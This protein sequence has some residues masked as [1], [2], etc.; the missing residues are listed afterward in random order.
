MPLMH[1]ALVTRRTA[2]RPS[3]W[4]LR[5]WACSSRAH[6][7]AVYWTAAA[8]VD[9]N[10]FSQQVTLS[11]GVVEACIPEGE[12]NAIEEGCVTYHDVVL[13]DA[14]GRLVDFSVGSERI[15]ERVVAGDGRLAS[16]EGVTIELV[17]AHQD[18]SGDLLTLF[19]STTNDGDVE[20]D[21]DARLLTPSG[22]VVTHEGF[23]DHAVPVGA[24]VR[25][26]INLPYGGLDGTL[27][28]RLPSGTILEVV[29]PTT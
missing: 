4:T 16:A 8:A 5:C 28:V 22:E 13:D 3:R 2:R 12:G 19:W 25:N 6:D 29:I 20:L 1:Q 27:Q 18:E 24:S 15:S 23:T 17:A 21:L 9:P 14:T 10:S 7:F 26:G 11:D